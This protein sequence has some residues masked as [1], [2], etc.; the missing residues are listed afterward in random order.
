MKLLLTQ[1][2]AT[3]LRQQ[4]RA[5]KPCWY[6]WS[7]GFNAPHNFYLCKY[8]KISFDFIY[9]KVYKNCG[10]ATRI[11]SKKSKWLKDPQLLSLQVFC[12]QT[13]SPARGISRSAAKR[14]DISERESDAVS[15]QKTKQRMGGKG[16]EP[17][18]PFGHTVLSRTRLPIPPPAH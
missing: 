6:I 8:F 3:D 9:C 16:L 2:T 5:I 4:L 13:R 11:R 12:F 14:S 1:N 10:A 7:G 15:K 17:L 18:S